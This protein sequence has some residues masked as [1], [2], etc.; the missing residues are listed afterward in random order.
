VALP[1]AAK[2][3]AAEAR[4]ANGVLTV[5]VPKA[6]EAKAKAITVKAA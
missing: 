1:E 4:Y 3:E 2:A 6:E 5:T